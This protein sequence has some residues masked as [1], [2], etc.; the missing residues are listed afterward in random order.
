MTKQLGFNLIRKHA[1]VEPERWYYWADRLGMLVWQDMPQMY[2][3]D[4]AGTLTDAGARSS[5]R[6]SGA[7]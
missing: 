7:D 1:K 2:A 3:D 6:P 4:T 5:S